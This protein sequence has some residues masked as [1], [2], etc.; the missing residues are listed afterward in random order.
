MDITE[1]KRAEIERFNLL[2]E[3]ET[4]DLLKDEFLR[5]V[6]HELRTP[7][8]IVLGNID[9]LEFEEPGSEDF[10][11]SIDAIKRAAGAQVRLVDD[12]LDISAI[13]S[14]TIRIEM[15]PVE[16]RIRDFESDQGKKRVKAVALTA[17]AHRDDVVKAIEGGFDAHIAKPLSLTS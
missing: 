4:A 9:L 8:T 13:H 16:I 12:L 3:S 11:H 1:R 10:F 14:G 7:M 6:S 5:A 17:H 15:K 2:A